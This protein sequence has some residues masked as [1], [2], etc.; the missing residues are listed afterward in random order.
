MTITTAKTPEAVPSRRPFLRLAPLAVAAMLLSAECHADWK[1]TPSIDL[2]ET[3][4]DNLGL[5]NDDLAHG[6]FVSEAAPRIS[7]LVNGPR[8]KLTGEAQWR[9]FAFSDS[10]DGN[11]GNN[12]N[13]NL[14]NSERRYNVDAQ[15]VLVDQLLYLDGSASRSRQSV[16]AFGQLTDNGYSA[17]NNADINIWRIS[18]YLRHRFGSN[19][20]A[21]LRLTR[22]SVD[23]NVNGY[24]DSKATTKS[25][26]VVSGSAFTT[27]AW[28][29]SYVRQDLSMTQD[30]GAGAVGSIGD[31]S[32]ETATLG[33]RWNIIPRFGLTATVGYDDYEYPSLNESTSGKSWTGGFV[34]TPSARTSL[35]AS[36]GRRYFGKTGSL[37]FSH[38]MRRSVWT[39]DYTDA[40]TTTRSQ[41]LLPATVN[42]AAMLDNLFS[43]SYP[44]PVQR[45]QAVQAYIASAGLPASLANSINYLT[46]RYIR[47]KRLQGAVAFRG[48]HSD[49]VLTVFRDERT[50]LSLQESDSPLTG[51]QLSSLNDNTRQRGAT[52]NFA[53]RL[54]SRTQASA[55]L[56]A[57]NVESLT[58][59]LTSNNR[60]ARL[61]LTRRFDAHTRG[62][63]D[64]RRSTG[65]QDLINN[66][67]YHENAIIATLSFV[68]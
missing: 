61:S 17:A 39:A 41:F 53:Y 23:G 51:N 37:A 15:S 55:N 52:A 24:G 65:R 58:T 47:V 57:I 32:Y 60:E 66:D 49:L 46:N 38:R 11:D 29:A 26:D 44:D 14:H 48:A 59:G 68:Y 3:Y 36:F 22:D 27:L 54:S 5:Q 9:Q 2:R 45:Q 33:G 56:S 4:S 13:A 19:A 20:V 40:V 64:L 1:V 50:A 25:A 62:S 10:N 8:L 16:S 7:V 67:S 31:S 34:W 35:Q 18:P 21:T 43:S 63:I 42:T 6:G 12:G 28:N 30:T